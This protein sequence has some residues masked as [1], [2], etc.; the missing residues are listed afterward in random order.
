MAAASCWEAQE[1]LTGVLFQCTWCNPQFFGGWLWRLHAPRGDLSSFLL[2]GW[3]LQA[4]TSGSVAVVTAGGTAAFERH[5]NPIQPP[6]LS[7]LLPCE[8]PLPATQ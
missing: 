1:E 6:E 7:A 2:P 3:R 8:F 4:F 5:N